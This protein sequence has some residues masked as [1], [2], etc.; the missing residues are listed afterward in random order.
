[1]ITL[2]GVH[3]VSKWLKLLIVTRPMAVPNGLAVH[4]Q[5][6]M[7][8]C[9]S[10]QGNTSRSIQPSAMPRNFHDWELKCASVA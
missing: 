3:E 7:K 2:V 1:M 6:N 5:V 8:F 9:A 10:G 4:V